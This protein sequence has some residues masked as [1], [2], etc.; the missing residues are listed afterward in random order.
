MRRCGDVIQTHRQTTAEM[1]A[2]RVQPKSAGA[3]VQFSAALSSVL[4]LTVQGF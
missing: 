2:L 4:A 1:V 3:A